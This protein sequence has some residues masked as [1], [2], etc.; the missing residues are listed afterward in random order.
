MPLTI[1][2]VEQTAVT[3]IADVE[4][5]GGAGPYTVPHGLTGTP[6]DVSFTW[7]VNTDTD[8]LNVTTIDATNVVF[9]SVGGAIANHDKLRLIARIAHFWPD[10]TQ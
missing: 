8:I 2:S 9:S 5:D 6:K 3:F 1:T 7:L 10:Q 4:F